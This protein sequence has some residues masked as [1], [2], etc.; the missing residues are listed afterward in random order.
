MEE[1]AT[2][3]CK[4]SN[5]KKTPDT[6]GNQHKTNVG[7]NSKRSNVKKRSDKTN[8]SHNWLL[9][10]LKGHTG[11]VMDMS[12]SSNGKYLATC[13]DGEL[14]MLL[15]YAIPDFLLTPHVH[16][17]FIIM[18]RRDCTAGMAWYTNKQLI[19]VYWLTIR[20]PPTLPSNWFSFCMHRW[21]PFV[22]FFPIYSRAHHTNAIISN[23]ADHST[24]ILLFSIQSYFIS[25]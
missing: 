8:Y 7:K 5:T 17:K 11:S 10:T 3:D 6:N 18:T 14:Q 25:F 19:I 22:L 23:F 4:S 12:F 20:P 16:Y 9:T 21:A 15:I 24:P 2:K 1:Y 13:A